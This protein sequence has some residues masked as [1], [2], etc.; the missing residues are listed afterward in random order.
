[1]LLAL[2]A[3]LRPGDEL[4]PGVRLRAVSAE[5]GLRYRVETAEGSLWV[6]LSPRG[7]LDRPA[8]RTARFDVGWRD[9]GARLAVPDE[10]ARALCERLAAL[11]ARN[12]PHAMLT[13]AA[14]GARVRRVR[15]PFALEPVTGAGVPHYTLSPYVGCLIGCGYCYAQRPVG[16]M[17]A[18]LGLP[19]A[20]W[21]SYTDV[22]ENVAER[23]TEELER[24]QPA[25]IKLCP[26]VTD[27]YHPIEARER[28]TRRCL[29]VLAGA[30]PRWPVLLLTRSALVLDD[31]SLLAAM[32]A[33]WAGVS[34]PAADT[35]T[36]RRFEPR[37]A[38]LDERLVVLRTLR[39]AGVRTFVVVQPILEDR[40]ERLADAIAS[41]AGTASVD[42]L[43][44][45]FGAAPRFEE[46]RYR[47]ML[48]PSWQREHAERLETMLEQRG[49][50]IWRAELPPEL[51]ARDPAR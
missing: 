20:P 39:D 47:A 24:L 11:V 29:H 15:V 8:A 35:E 36:L 26:I 32:P 17:R 16:A 38:S 40:L 37:A 6:E 45:A 19:E 42:V 9:E 3:P 33:L 49:V 50:R 44:G 30:G 14:S 10:R 25:P 43:R 34:L 27:P 51:C 23:L 18:L 41:V 48:D 31:V 28:L 2:V 12:E 5:V 4:A 13:P 7:A 1:M 46:P 22:R 21:G